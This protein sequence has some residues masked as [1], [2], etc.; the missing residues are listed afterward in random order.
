MT[1]RITIIAVLSVSLLSAG[2]AYFYRDEIE[3]GLTRLDTWGPL[4]VAKVSDGDTIRVRAQSGKIRT[5][6]LRGINAPELA[7]AGRIN[8][9]RECYAEEATRALG[10]MLEGNVVAIEYDHEV[11]DDDGRLIGFVFA[12]SSRLHYFATLGFG[13]KHV[14]LALLQQ[15]FAEDYLYR[16][17]PH[18]F[19]DAFLRAETQAKVAS[20]NGWGACED[21]KK[22]PRRQKKRRTRS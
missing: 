14:N 2:A 4:S 8:R 12:Y 16:N 13:G 21:F 11:F 5:L 18:R 6:R 19:A 7:H 22:H 15:G 1:K 3:I 10:A 20:V 9:T 17:K